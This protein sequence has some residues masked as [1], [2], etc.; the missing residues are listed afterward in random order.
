MYECMHVWMYECT[1]AREMKR[2]ERGEE[3]EGEE[4]SESYTE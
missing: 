4:A 2:S 1:N 3:S